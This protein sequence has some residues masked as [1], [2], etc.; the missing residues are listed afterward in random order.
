MTDWSQLTKSGFHYMYTTCICTAA[1][2]NI[3]VAVF[4]KTQW[5]EDRG[6]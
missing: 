4:P 6:Q 2:Q 5:S 1:L 3:H